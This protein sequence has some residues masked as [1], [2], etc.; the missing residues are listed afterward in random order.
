MVVKMI[1]PQRRKIRLI[2]LWR[3]TDVLAAILKHQQSRQYATTILPEAARRRCKPRVERPY[4]LRQRL[5][6]P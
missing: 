6:D 4:D 5:D 3:K 2:P 1:T